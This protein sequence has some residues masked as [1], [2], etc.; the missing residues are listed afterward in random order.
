MPAKNRRFVR[1]ELD[2]R[3][4]LP[5]YRQIVLQLRH[6]TAT[7]RLQP[8]AQLPTVRELARRLGVNFNT[9]ARAYR[10]L[11]REGTLSTQPGRGTFVLTASPRRGQRALQELAANYIAG[12]RRLQFNDAQIAA[13]I[14]RR[15][16]H[17]AAR[18]SS[19]ENH[20]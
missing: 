9:V 3:L 8:G 16:G 18:T 14:Q 19:G 13:A 17:R 20:G 4:G 7:G 10:L 1:I 12:A 6:H 11:A 2:P 5:V 15:I